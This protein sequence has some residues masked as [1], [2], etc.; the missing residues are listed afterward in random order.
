MSSPVVKHSVV[1]GDHKTSVTLE[2][3]FW[4]EV[5]RIAADQGRTVGQYITAIDASRDTNNLSSALR[6]AVISDLRAKISLQKT[7]A[8]A[9]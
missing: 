8:N 5:K 9:A 4:H 1:I 3:A 6:L 2:A 7:S